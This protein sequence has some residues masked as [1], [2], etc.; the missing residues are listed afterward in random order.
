MVKIKKVISKKKVKKSKDKKI[1]SG[2]LFLTAFV[3]T[4]CFCIITFNLGKLTFVHGKEY[5]EQAYNQQ[6]KNQIISPRRGIIYDVSGNVLAKSVPVDTVSLNPG[7]VCYSNKKVVENEVLAQGL[8]QTL[9]LDY[10][11]I[12]QK[13]TTKSSVAVIA[14]KVEKTKIDALKKWMSENKITTG[15]NIDEDTKRYYPYHNVA[16]NLIG[17]CGDSNSGIVGLEECWNKVL[18]GTA[19]KIVTMQDV[20]K[21]AI[22]DETEQYVP[23]ENG[24]NIYL[25]IDLTVQQIAEKYLKQA[26]EQNSCTGGGNVIIMNP[27]NG[28]ILA[29]ATYPDYN[30]NLPYEIE[31]T[32]QAEIWNT[33]TTEQKTSEYY[34]LWMNKSVSKLY[35]P[36]STFKIIT[37]AVALEEDL[38]ETDHACDFMC[39]GSIQVEDYNI[40]CWRDDPHGAQTLREALCNSCNPAF[41]QL[42]QKVGAKTLYQYYDAFGLFD[43]LGNDIARTY[44][45]VFHKLQN[46]GKVELATTSFGQRFE[47]SPLQLITAVSTVANDGKFV[48]PKIVKKIENPDTG[49]IEMQENKEVRQVV[50]KETSEKIRNMLHSVVVQG[51]G[52][53]AAVEGY[54][55][56][57]KSGT[58]EPRMGNEDAGYVASFIAISPI[59]NPQIAVL[60]VL[61]DPEGETFQ[62]GQTAGPVAANI[63]SEVLPY[64]GIH[65]NGESVTTTEAS[66]L[67]LP[68]VSSK[69]VTAAKEILQTYGFQV[70]V[71]T[72]GD[73]NT[74]VVADQMPKPG[75][76]LEKGAT[77]YLYGE[78]DDA[79]LSVKV[80]SVTGLTIEEAKETLK[81]SHLN[82]KIEGENGIIISQEP[83]ANKSVEKGTIVDVVVEKKEN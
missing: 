12:L 74:Q 5:S 28:E 36:G 83:A 35:E 19:G 48:E 34:K 26:V 63:L 18:T 6:M 75:V 54:T 24:S 72:Q 47:I 79:R 10:N 25:T 27:Q 45:S 14:K 33:L 30:L 81:G 37:A 78:G 53:R 57:G 31:P 80:P 2:K 77:V 21:N 76:T 46:V 55:I 58:S 7:K 9:E 42:G 11:E 61:Y 23:V 66:N 50:S 73:E 15:I 3:A 69:T 62:G 41:V 43:T 60:T 65:K 82:I 22:S 52:K 49:V 64:L 4:I 70:V 56:G 68:N 51:T 40:E 67:T 29:M 59:E 16:S 32:G 38:I 13:I 20:K 44:K 71:E 1:V 17:I 8:A 39:T